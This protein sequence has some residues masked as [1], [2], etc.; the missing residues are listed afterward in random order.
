MGIKRK[1]VGTKI[2]VSKNYLAKS[3]WRKKETNKS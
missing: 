1:K 2:K 3:I